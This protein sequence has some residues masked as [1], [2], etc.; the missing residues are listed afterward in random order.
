[1]RAFWSHSAA[2]IEGETTMKHRLFVPAVIALA[3]A[4]AVAQADVL[5]VEATDNATVRPDG[6]RSGSSGKAFFNVEGSVNAAFASYGVA[7]FSFGTLSSTVLS[8]NSISLSLTQSNA[9]F[10]TD[11]G[12]VISLDTTASPVDIQPG[13]SPL[14]FDGADPGT[15]TDVSDGDLT[16]SSLGGPF[17]FTQVANGNVDVYNLTLDA[18]SE[19]AIIAALNGGGTI[20]IVLGSGDTTVAATYAGTTNTTYDGPVLALDV[21]TDQ[22]GV[23]ATHWSAIKGLYR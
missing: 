12:L 21:T 6:P 15:A 19:A 5:S 8:I 9:A 11:G 23:E 1:V 16:L 18:G 2:D 13:T 17:T 20:R 7:D 22:V 4:V 10:T 14:A 3:A